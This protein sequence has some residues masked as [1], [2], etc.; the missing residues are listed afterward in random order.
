MKTKTN[1]DALRKA[2]ALIAL[3]FTF[4]ITSAQI[5]TKFFGCTLGQ[6]TLAT[7]IANLRARN[8][9]FVVN[10]DGSILITDCRFGGYTWTLT[11][12][13]F[14]EGRLYS[15]LFMNDGA[16]DIE[17]YNS[18]VTT[19]DK[20]YSKY[21]Y[22]SKSDRSKYQDD[23]TRVTTG[24]KDNLLNAKCFALSYIDKHLDD[25]QNEAEEDEF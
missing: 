24:Y 22:E 1:K 2:I 15:V 14:Y 3:C 5:Q 18:L 23:K 16:V 7:A 25:L 11:S 6:T 10:P 4:T 20:K 19:L 12:F 8:I 21:K 13:Y 9:L 17:L